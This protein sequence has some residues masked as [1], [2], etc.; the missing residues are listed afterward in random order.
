MEVIKLWVTQAEAQYW[1]R[2][3]LRYSL[4]VYVHWPWK[5]TKGSIWDRCGASKCPLITSSLQSTINITWL[6]EEAIVSMRKVFSVWRNNSWMCKGLESLY[7]LGDSYIQS[8]RTWGIF[9]WPWF[10]N[11][12]ESFYLCIFLTNDGL[13]AKLCPTLATPW[14]VAHQT[15]LSMR[16]SR[17]EYWNGLSFPSLGDQTR[18]SCMIRHQN[19]QG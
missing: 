14:T 8:F 13:V 12:T 16:S 7:I 17:Q 3:E 6:L 5:E 10:D 15:P 4:T 2:W 18:V 9:K 1:G 19:L 11:Y